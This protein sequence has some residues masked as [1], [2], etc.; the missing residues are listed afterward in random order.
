LPPEA[1]AVPQ[2]STAAAAN[3]DRGIPM[4]DRLDRVFENL[5][6]VYFDWYARLIPGCFGVALYLYLSE[7]IRTAPTGAEVVLFLLFG[8]GLGHALQPL[9]GV[10]VKRVEKL[11]PSEDNY[12]K[13]KQEDAMPS[14][15]RKV[16][17][18][19]AEANSMLAFSFALL[20]NIVWFWNSP[21]LNKGVAFVFLFYFALAAVERTWARDRKI[22]DLGKPDK[23]LA[24]GSSA[25]A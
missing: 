1:F 18:A 23:R 21:R 20:L 15:L 24:D 9:A 10:L 7:S 3:L 2:V 25:D 14:L 11:Y 5:P 17:K 19:H 13:A 4:S 16:S 6:D 12:K 8:Y 22:K